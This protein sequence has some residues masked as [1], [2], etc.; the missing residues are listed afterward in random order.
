MP[1]RGCGG[2]GGA[3]LT[4]GARRHL[5]RPSQVTVLLRDDELDP[6][7]SS[8]RPPE[9][10]RVE[11]F[12]RAQVE[13]GR[14][15]VVDKPLVVEHCAEDP[16]GLRASRG[17]FP[18][19]LIRDVRGGQAP[20]QDGHAEDDDDEHMEVLEKASDCPL[21]P[22]ATRMAFRGR[23]AFRPAPVTPERSVRK[24]SQVIYS[25]ATDVA[26]VGGVRCF[27]RQRCSLPGL[28]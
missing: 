10:R 1:H 19:F 24:S 15:P 16:R 28:V 8:R 26:A 23:K 11:A 12:K 7:V 5:E 14:L 18:G 9:F 22:H 3:V 13:E 6:R 2:G 17:G 25:D 20:H 27:P 4:Q 21:P